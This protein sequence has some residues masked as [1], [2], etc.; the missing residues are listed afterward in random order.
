MSLCAPVVELAVAPPTVFMPA[1]VGIQ[2]LLLVKARAIRSHPSSNSSSILR[3]A[4]LDVVLNS[5]WIWFSAIISLDY[6]DSH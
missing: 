2:E 5:L 6:V 4:S 3:T 1:P